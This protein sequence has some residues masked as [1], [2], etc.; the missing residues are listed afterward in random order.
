MTF[1]TPITFLTIENINP[2][3][4]TR[5]RFG[6]SCDV[7]VVGTLGALGLPVRPVLATWV[8]VPA[9]CGSHSCFCQMPSKLSVRNRMKSV[10]P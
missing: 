10:E 9:G 4:G 6:I 3:I 8:I 7:L 1:E 5:K 2:D